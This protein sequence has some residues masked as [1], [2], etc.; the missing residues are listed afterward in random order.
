MKKKPIFDDR[1]DAIGRIQREGR[2]L[3]GSPISLYQGAEAV[4]WSFQAV[5]IEEG[6]NSQK[7][8]PIP[9]NFVKNWG[10]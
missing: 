9:R 8:L 10:L 5:Q 3:I 2:F 1:L 4:G 6:E 7:Y